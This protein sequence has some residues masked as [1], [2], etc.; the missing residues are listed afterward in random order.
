MS[1]L[2]LDPP[3]PN[4]LYRTAQALARAGQPVF[5]C[6]STGERAKQPLVRGGFKAA[7]CDKAQIK[8]WWRQY[9]DAAIG[10]PTNVMWD[11]LDV[12]IKNESDGR[13]HL[14]RLHRLGLL[15]GC[16]RVVRTPSGGWHLY[17]RATP[18]LTGTANAGLGL[19]VRA[20]GG[21]V[22]AAGSYIETDSYAGFYTDEGE[23]TDS[24]DDPLL[25]S[26]IRNDLAPVNTDD[27]KPI[28]TPDSE[29]RTSLASLR[30]W[31]SERRQGERNNSFHWAVHRCIEAGID[32][33]EL[34]EVAEFIGLTPDEITK[35]IGSAL[36]RVGVD[37][38]E[39]KTEAEAL[40][41]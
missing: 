39:L 38:S 17:F 30:K 34:S 16:K 40:F 1:G 6:R 36:H 9:G 12:D 4:D 29:R 41:G 14:V 11:V 22:L 10:I 25:W 26:I 23:T 27:N 7:T 20:A 8:A 32:P 24:T 13:S 3:S 33:H 35:T 18:G 31:L 15:N 2:V 19:D 5:P 21:Y 28:R 37:A